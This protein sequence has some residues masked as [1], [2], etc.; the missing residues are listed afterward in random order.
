[1]NHARHIDCLVGFLVV[2]LFGCLVC[3]KTLYD[4]KLI[5]LLEVLL[6]WGN[7]DMLQNFGLKLLGW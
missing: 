7:V 4:S 3:T 6:R 2:W 1:M 5:D